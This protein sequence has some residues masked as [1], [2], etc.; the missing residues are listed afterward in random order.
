MFFFFAR[1]QTVLIFFVFVSALLGRGNTIEQIL[2]LIGDTTNLLSFFLKK[3]EPCSSPIQNIKV[4]NYEVKRVSFNFCGRI[5]IVHRIKS[6]SLTRILCAVLLSVTMFRSPLSFQ[7]IGVILRKLWEY[8]ADAFPST[9]RF[10]H[11][12]IAIILTLGNCL[13]VEKSS[14]CKRWLPSKSLLYYD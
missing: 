12:I 7:S 14:N 1:I 6:M 8:M 4:R 11:F 13:V 10:D 9:H 5:L 3:A 2:C